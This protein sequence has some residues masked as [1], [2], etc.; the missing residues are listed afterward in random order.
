MCYTCEHG[1]GGGDASAPICG[2]K[3]LDFR[4]MLHNGD[5]CRSCTPGTGHTNS[6]VHELRMGTGRFLMGE[7]KI[8]RL[9]CPV[10]SQMCTLWPLR[11]HQG[12]FTFSL[13]QL[14][15]PTSLV[16]HILTAAVSPAFL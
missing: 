3:L 11:F 4:K 14:Y 9:E 5:A 7:K 15:V 13:M 10:V 2:C 8:I 6:V 1:A 16:L 12:F